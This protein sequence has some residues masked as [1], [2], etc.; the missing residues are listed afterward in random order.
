MSMQGKS[1][2]EKPLSLRKIALF[3][4]C[5]LLKLTVFEQFIYTSPFFTCLISKR[6]HFREFTHTTALQPEGSLSANSTKMLTS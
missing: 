1:I 2:L 3:S 4:I 5:E 6:S